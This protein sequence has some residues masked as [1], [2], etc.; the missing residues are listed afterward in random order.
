MKLS[1]IAEARKVGLYLDAGYKHMDISF[2]ATIYEGDVHDPILDG[3][4]WLERI[5]TLK[6]EYNRKGIQ[7]VPSLWKR[8]DVPQTKISTPAARIFGAVSKLTLPST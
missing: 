1:A 5:D 6:K 7:I 3:E 4:D 2:C 8:L